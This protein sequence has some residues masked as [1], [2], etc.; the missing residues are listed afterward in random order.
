MSRGQQLKH[1]YCGLYTH[2]GIYTKDHATTHYH[3]LLS[4]GS[5]W[6]LVGTGYDCDGT[7]ESHH[8]ERL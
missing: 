2:F 4:G 8:E 5:S 1:K 6:A 3:P 7:D